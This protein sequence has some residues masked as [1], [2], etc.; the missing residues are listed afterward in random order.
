VVRKTKVKESSPFAMLLSRCEGG[1]TGC[2]RLLNAKT[3]A[4]RSDNRHT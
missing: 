2:G 4:E 1:Q 3:D